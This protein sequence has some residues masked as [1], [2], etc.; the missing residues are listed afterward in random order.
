VKDWAIGH[1]ST[2]TAMPYRST[3]KAISR[4][5]VAEYDFLDLAI[6]SGATSASRYH[7]IR[8]KETLESV[9]K[10]VQ[11]LV[12]RGLLDGTADSFTIT[13]L[14]EELMAEA[15]TVL[16]SHEGNEKVPR[17]QCGTTGRYKSGCRCHDCSEAFR[18][19]HREYGRRKRQKL[20]DE[21][22]QRSA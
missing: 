20:R 7:S 1:A 5:F 2:R 12:A 11:R 21:R 3:G 6:R 10:T 9:R 19:Y 14:A 22:E 17:G 13:P 4:L 15:D 8:G 18:A 16:L